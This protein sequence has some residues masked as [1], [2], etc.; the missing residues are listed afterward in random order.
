MIVE[1]TN[2][3][4]LALVEG[5]PVCI[6]G[7]TVRRGDAGVLH[8]QQDQEDAIAARVRERR[9]DTRH[10]LTGDPQF[11]MRAKFDGRCPH[12]FCTQEEI[13]EGDRVLRDARGKKTYCAPCGRNLFPNVIDSRAAKV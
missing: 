13:R 4:M 5:E 2:A 9:T 10:Q 12:A 6:G 8:E 7:V 1:L 3:H 11:Y